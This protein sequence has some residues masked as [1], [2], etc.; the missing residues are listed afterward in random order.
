MTKD[1]RQFIASLI[2][3]LDDK[4]TGLDKKIDEVDKRLSTEIRHNGVLIEKMQGDIDF[5]VEGH[6]TLNARLIRVEA[7]VTEI[8][9]TIFDYPILRDVVKEHSRLLAVK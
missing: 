4:I 8:K 5:L 2:K 3:G 1:D 6:Q 9:E 7:D